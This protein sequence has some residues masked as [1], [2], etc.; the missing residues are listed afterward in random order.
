ME[1]ESADTHEVISRAEAAQRGLSRF[2]TGRPCKRGHE[3]QR[4]VSNKQCVTCNAIAAKE[5]EDRRCRRDP[6]YRMFRSVHRRSGQA[7]RGAYSPTSALGCSL[8]A[9]SRHIEEQFK[10]GMSWDTYGQWEVDHIVPLSGANTLR[11][12]ISLCH[13]TNL[14]PLWKR[15]NLIKGGA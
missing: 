10:T 4:Y 13:Y 12:A 8:P 6:A 3:A 1:I 11:D 5:T 14:Q 15:E 7:L 9:L 2:Y